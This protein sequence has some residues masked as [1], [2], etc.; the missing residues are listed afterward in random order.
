MKKFTLTLVLACIGVAMAAQTV[1]TNWSFCNANGNPPTFPGFDEITLLENST[2]HLAVGTV[3]GHD[4]VFV[5][6]TAGDVPN[7]FIYNSSDGKDVGVVDGT[8]EFWGLG[9]PVSLK[10]NDG[11]VTEDGKILVNN[12]VMSG[13]FK[14]YKWESETAMINPKVVINYNFYSGRYGD[15]V[16]YTG[17]Y[18][19][20]TAKI[21]AVNKVSGSTKV[22]CWSMVPDTDNP[23]TYKFNNTPA[24]LFDVVANN[25]NPGVGLKPD[26]GFYFKDGGLQ[27]VEYSST[28][29]LLNTSPASV[30]SASGHTVRYIGKEGADEFIAYFKYS[31][32]ETTAETA[33]ENVDIL[34]VPGGDLSKAVLVA[35]T[36]SLGTAANPN[37]SGDV[38]VRRVGKNVEIFVISAT[39]GFGKYTV[40]NV[41]SQTPMENI[42]KDNVKILN[43]SNI[44]LVEGDNISGIEVYNALGQM[45]KYQS[46]NYDVKVGDLKGIYIVKVKVGGQLAKIAKVIIK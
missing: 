21:Y 38:S 41:F 8:S 30:V 34:K 27:I 32:T 13:N 26:G 39:N 15:N 37:G 25:S 17:N 29:T 1:T 36:P 24:E 10:V 40:A 19:T 20:G 22:L 46:N 42:E 18:N 33:Q 23:G 45:V 44:L 43:Q 7:V 3:N 2:R 35:T 6:S 12:I 11:G 4:G 5:I 31:L 16:T 9:S 28:G 14:V